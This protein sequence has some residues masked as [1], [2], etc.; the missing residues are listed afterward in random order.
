M[1]PYILTLFLFT[2][3]LGTTI[4]FASTHWLLAW[5][6]LEVNTLAFIP[7][8]LR[9]SHPRAV[10]AAT[11]YFLTQASAAALIFYAALINAW[12]T[13][14]WQLDGTYHPA[15]AC[16]ITLGLGLKIGLAPLHTWVPQVLQG[17][18]LKTGLILSTWQKLAP[19]ALLIQIPVEGRTPLVLLALASTL[20]GGWGGM[21]QTQLRKILAYSSIAHM[22]WV[23]LIIQFS[24][25][26]TLLTLA[27]YM[28]MTSASFLILKAFEAKNINGLATSWVKAPLLAA[29]FPMVF[30]SLAG[31]PPFSGF[32]PKWLIFKELISNKEAFVALSAAMSSLLALYFYARVVHALASTVAPH[33]T[34]ASTTWRLPPDQLTTVLML[35]ITLASFSLPIVPAITAITQFFQ[36]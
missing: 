15:V 18:D 13:G 36:Q 17:L 33:L 14:Q 4:T 24:P 27:L 11:K 12:E 25:S 19:F 2:L 21:N 6:G 5:M 3:G 8:M 31:L 22:G 34:N 35:F 7:L 26:L 32:A 9:H 20:V 16:A 23:I 29:L 28:I 30:L 1:S 10:E